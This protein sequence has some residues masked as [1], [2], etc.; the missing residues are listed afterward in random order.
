MLYKKGAVVTLNGEE[1]LVRGH[2]GTL[3]SLIL[4]Q[5]AKSLMQ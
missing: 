4:K 5:L 3:L 1:D 2:S